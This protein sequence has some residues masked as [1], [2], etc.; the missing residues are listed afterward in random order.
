[1]NWIAASARGRFHYGWVAAAVVFLI[2]LAAAGTRATPSVLMVPLGN[3]FGWSRATVSLAISI[4]IAL[5]GLTG[6]FAAAAMQRFGLRPTIL[7]ALVVMGTGV[8]LSSMMTATWQM[9]LIWGVMVGS[10]TGVAALTLS[11][12]FV[13]RW[14]VARR[15]LVMGMLTAS[16]ATGQMVF[17]PMLASI[18]ERHGWRPVVLVVAVALAIVV[19]LVIFLL[20]ERPADVQLRPYGEPEDAPRAAEAAKQNPLATAFEA[21]FSAARRRDF[22]LLFFSFFI[23][24]AS[25]NGYIGSHLI[26]MCSDYGMSEVQGASLLAAMG[27]FDLI[28]TTASGWLSDRYDSRV[29]LFW[30]YGLRGLSLIY[31]P[32]AFGI[33]FFGLPLFAVF[34]GLDWIATVPP[35][36]R[37]ATD[38]W[39]KERAPIVFGWIVA[40]H[41]LGA[42]FAT[43]GAG[44][45]RASLGT[46]TL[47]SMISGGL[48][49]VGA[50][51]V[52]RIG[53][54]R[55]RSVPQAA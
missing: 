51:I 49:I 33:D 50:L 34:Y 35:T 43:L 4:N 12:T 46:Y 17:L 30:Y 25:T 10:A 19:P 28:G 24:G 14:F 3:E 31:L 47:A 37:L 13:N 32:H 21:L 2:L 26:A 9:V 7:T 11:A 36:V 45:L 44:L 53:R 8:A 54:G 16:S 22:W 42:A 27:I 15:G 23:C 55:T 29:L 40:G 5:Y 1:M 39:G 41:Q 18:S 48:C 20:P 52:L 38:I 6:P